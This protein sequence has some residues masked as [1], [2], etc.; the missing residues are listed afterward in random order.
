MTMDAN[1]DQSMDLLYQSEAD[2]I[3]I[4]IGSRIDP[5]SYTVE[6]FFTN[7]ALSA[8]DNTDC[9]NPN[10]SDLISMPN[11]NAF[12]DLNGD[13]LPDLV[14]T[15]QAGT[16]DEMAKDGSSVKTYYEVYS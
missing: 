11:S 5:L 12:I 1:T 16:P 2:G 15:R 8:Q 9:K 7:Y 6:D 4:A 14:L 10:T 13:C 3:K